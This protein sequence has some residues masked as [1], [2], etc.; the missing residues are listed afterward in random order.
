MSAL[1]IGLAA[2]TAAAPPCPPASVP[3]PPPNRPAYALVVHVHRDLRGADGSETVAFRP[4]VATDRVVLRLWANGPAYE[5]DGASL[6][7]RD[8]TAAG[9]RVPTSRPGPTIL[10]VRRHLAAGE[11]VVL[12]LRWALVL[13][14]GDGARMHG[15]G[16]MRL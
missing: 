11:R 5:R 10:V 14:R 4:A 8:V 13:P 9:R 16:T 6:T 3:A 7:V 15:G 12:R 1:A 2:L